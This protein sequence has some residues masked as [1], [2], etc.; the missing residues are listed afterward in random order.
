MG[1][2]ET[3]LPACLWLLSRDGGGAPCVPSVCSGGGCPDAPR[4]P[5]HVG[6]HGSLL[7]VPV[8]LASQVDSASAAA[9]THASRVGGGMVGSPQT[10]APSCPPRPTGH[11]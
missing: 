7:S 10:A 11:Q 8:S 5:G 6:G 2:C 4:L 1:R 3:T 9:S